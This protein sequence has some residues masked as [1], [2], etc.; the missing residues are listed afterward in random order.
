MHIED[1]E[2]KYTQSKRLSHKPF[3]YAFSAFSFSAVA[4][5]TVDENGSEL[6]F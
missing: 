1:A 4:E 6:P 3:I 5:T 2:A